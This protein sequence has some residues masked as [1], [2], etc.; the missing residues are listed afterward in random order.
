[1][2]DNGYQLQPLIFGIVIGTALLTG[3]VFAGRL[4]FSYVGAGSTEQKRRR[5][6][7]RTERW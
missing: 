2:M 6:P 5:T 7:R 4:I 1:M 3:L